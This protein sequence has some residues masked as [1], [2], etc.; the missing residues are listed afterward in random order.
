MCD[1]C[2]VWRRSAMLLWFI[3]DARKGSG[4]ILVVRILRLLRLPYR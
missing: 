2:G 4:E 3:A 1:V